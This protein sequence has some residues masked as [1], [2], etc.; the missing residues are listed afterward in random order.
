MSAP[1]AK[2]RAVII[3]G[4]V[5]GCSV[6]YHLAK[7]GWTRRRAARAQAAHLR[8]HL[9]RRRAHRP[10]A[11][12]A[13]P[14]PARQI[15]GRALRRGWRPRRALPPASARR[16]DHLALTDE[17]LR[18]A[19]RGRP[20]WRG[21]RRRGAKCSPARGAGEVSADRRRRAW[22]AAVSSAAD[23]QADPANIAM[24]LAKGARQR[25]AR[26]FE[27]IKVTG[28]LAAGGRVTGVEHRTE[29]HDRAPSIV[30][31][32]AGMWA[33]ELG[34]M[35]GVNVPLQACEHFYIVT[36]AMPG[37]RATCRCCAC[38]TSAPT[39]RRTPASCCSA[40]SSR[41][42]SPGAWTASPRTSSSTSCPRTW[43]ISSR[44]WRWRSER[45][46]I[47]ERVGI[48]TFFNGP[49]SFTPDGRY[50][51][52]RGAGAR[53]IS[54]SRPASIRSASR[55]RA[56]PAWRWPNGWRPASRR[57]T[58]GTSTSAACSR[59]RATGATCAT[60]STETLGLHY[61]D[62]FPYRQIRDAR[63]ACARSP[64][65]E[66]LEGARRLLRR[67]RPA[68]SAPN[69]FAAAHGA[70]APSTATA[71][72]GRTGSST[73]RRSTRPCARRRPVRPVVLRQDPRRGPRRARPCCSA[74]A[75]TTSPWRRAASS[76]RRWL[77]ARGGIEADL[78]VTRLS[79]TCSSSSRRRHG[80]A[81][82]RLAE[83]P[84]PDGAHCVVTD[85]TAGRGVLGLMGPRS[86]ELLAAGRTTSPTTA[87]PFGTCREIEIG[88]RSPARTASPMSAS[89]AGSSTSPADM[90]AHCVRHARCARRRGRP[91]AVRHARAR[92]AAAWRRPIATT[93]TTSPTDHVLEA[94]LGFAV[95][96]RGKL[97][98]FIGRD[99]VLREEQA[100][101]S[102]RL[103]QFL[104][105]DPGRCSTATRRSCATARIVGT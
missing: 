12:L 66:R 65:H 69:W 90:A 81:R 100:G 97:G 59:S 5:S 60:A 15:F 70:G 54:S 51:A 34:R 91:E 21:L 42:P 38:R 58:S 30:V 75:P 25:G 6:A 36:E 101:L 4:G 20:R 43:T 55:P 63:A 80:A 2:A 76:T 96:P 94:G 104:L 40:P 22:S 85:V 8:H 84:H 95:K 35:A 87:F 29:A 72:G 56:A 103:V 49:E 68:G 78:T 89:S 28:V 105:A 71:G 41:R 88:M 92:T 48:H 98:D 11:R 62:Q 50:Y 93:A 26:I 61:A 79:E 7:L 44:C 73:A 1:P 74:S 82:S 39:T 24:A 33:R 14:D 83:A 102:R 52:R 77:N 67:G 18:G 86:R 57:S 64:L 99:A 23:G 53:G 9:A 19:L 46:P 3:G 17:R 45:M 13:E 37:L 47:L 31:N 10:A 32:C 27:N 16:L